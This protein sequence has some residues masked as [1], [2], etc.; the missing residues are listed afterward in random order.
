MKFTFAKKASYAALA[1]FLALALFS[2]ENSVSS[3]DTIETVVPVGI[4]NYFF[5]DATSV[6][7]TEKSYVYGEDGKACEMRGE[8]G[9]ASYTVTTCYLDGWEDVP[10]LSLEDTGKM[11]SLFNGRGWAVSYDSAAGV[12]K[13][14]YN[15]ANAARWPSDWQ[16]SWLNDTLYFDPKTQT[17]YSDEFVRLINDKKLVNNG[18]GGDSVETYESATDE[19][20][21]KIAFS[22]ATDQI[23]QP[24]EKTTIDLGRY[25][26]KMF[27]IGGKLYIPF[28][29]LS[30]VFLEAVN[31]VFNGT[32][33]YYSLDAGNDKNTMHKAF[34]SGRSP[35][36]VRSRL[37]AEYSY[38][39]LCL[40]FDANYCLKNQRAQIGKDNIT[41]F[42]DSIFKAG[43]GYDLLSTDTE[44]YDK[45]L[46]R[47]LMGYID[48]GHTSYA[49]PSMYQ[50]A[51]AVS[52]Y[53][54][55]YRVAVAGPRDIG[56]S[57][58]YHDLAN[59]RKNAGGL[60][61]NPNNEPYDGNA[62]WWWITDSGKDA[63]AIFAFD[64]FVPS[65]NFTPYKFLTDAFY[66]STNGIQTKH[67][68][69]KNIVIDLSC[70]GGGAIN[71]C[72]AA[73]CFFGDNVCMPQKN[74]L[75]NSITRFRYVVKDGSS[76]KPVP[77]AGG[78][79]NFYVLT[80]GF[81]FSCGNYFPA[82]CKYQFGIP[83]VGQRSGGGGGVVKAT[84]TTDGA[85]FN[86]SAAR[87]MCAIDAGG[88]Y[89]SIDHGVPVDLEIPYE[90]FYGDSTGSGTVYW[91]LYQ[92]LKTAYPA[93]FN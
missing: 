61:S 52:F 23:K 64:S 12:Y 82:I 74:H 45:A 88:N 57:K 21:P 78:S 24:K 36:A 39:V 29:A 92:K 89:V 14:N 27:E 41:L 59:R 85:V 56:L 79:Y 49:E 19:F 15:Q 13:Y 1:L 73:L 6:C 47:F 2:C 66:D 7:E 34:E 55:N 83:I 18:Y 30:T 31:C 17:V 3:V 28:Q 50:P 25:G 62:N 37:M 54:N 51:S 60:G 46:V 38:R 9:K 58:T 48:D 53:Y 91:D 69:I 20:C 80:S 11:L 44:T 90:A 93:N 81:S 84:Q 4:G 87:E 35:R 71:Q 10:F 86:T 40:S 32:D 65:D 63:L 43:L 75:D 26:L 16:A 8:D 22:P 77:S 68:D 76:L 5:P 67:P 33:Y 72:M 42:N 70:N